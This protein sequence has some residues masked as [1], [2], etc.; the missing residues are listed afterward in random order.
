MHTLL[1]FLLAMIAGSCPA[2]LRVV[3]NEDRLPNT[4]ND[5]WPAHWFYS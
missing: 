5:W 1:P 3:K 2:E 4:F